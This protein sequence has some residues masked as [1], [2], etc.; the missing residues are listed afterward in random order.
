MGQL[1]SAARAPAPPTHDAS[2]A[3]TSPTDASPTDAR[4]LPHRRLAH[5]RT[6][7]NPNQHAFSNNPR[8]HPR[9]TPPHIGGCTLRHNCQAAAFFRSAGAS[10][11]ANLV[12]RNNPSE[13]SG[14]AYPAS[15]HGLPLAVTYPRPRQWLSPYAS[16]PALLPRRHFHHPSEHVPQVPRRGFRRLRRLKSPADTSQPD[17]TWPNSIYGQFSRIMEDSPPPIN[18][19]EST[20]VHKLVDTIHRKN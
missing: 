13:L 9:Y 1:P 5:R 7:P 6:G 3:D 12:Y 4:R 16:E 2:P 11:L 18:N 17:L 14:V 15:L 8:I 20:I 10:A 19:R